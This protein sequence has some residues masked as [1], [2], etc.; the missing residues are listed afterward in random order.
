M[1]KTFKKKKLRRSAIYNWNSIL[2]TGLANRCG[3]WKRWSVESEGK[4]NLKMK[5]EV[6]YSVLGPYET[7]IAGSK[8]AKFST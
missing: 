5:M 8:N 4:K 1:Y 6:A 7:A 2:K 3:F